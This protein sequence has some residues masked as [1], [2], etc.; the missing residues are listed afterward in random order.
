MACLGEWSEETQLLAFGCSDR[1]ENGPGKLFGVSGKVCSGSKSLYKGK[2]AAVFQPRA[3]A[4][5]CWLQFR[6]SRHRRRSSLNKSVNILVFGRTQC[7]SDVNAFVHTSVGGRSIASL[8]RVPTSFQ[9]SDGLVPSSELG[10]LV[11]PHVVLPVD[12]LLLEASLGRT[13]GSS[14]SSCSTLFSP[15]GG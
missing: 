11:C 5:W 15:E 10:L 6:Y 7:D 8:P 4:A 13:R 14:G 12:S 3:V 1:K 2:Y 9:E